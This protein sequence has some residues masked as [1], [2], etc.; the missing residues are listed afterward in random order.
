M[1]IVPLRREEIPEIVER[2][3]MDEL[4]EWLVDERDVR[5]AE[6]VMNVL[7]RPKDDPVE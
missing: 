1:P 6:Q 2:L 4:A 3:G 7:G 5:F